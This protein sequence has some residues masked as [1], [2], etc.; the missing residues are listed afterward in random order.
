M[1]DQTLYHYRKERGICV[2]CGAP[3]VKGKTRCASCAKIDAVKS[4]YRYHKMSEEQLAIKR[5]RQNKWFADHHDRVAIYRQR[6][7]ERKNRESMDNCECCRNCVYYVHDFGEHWMCYNENSK[8]FADYMSFSQVCD[9]FRK[10][11][12]NYEHTADNEK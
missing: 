9:C 4:K 12:G 5:E 1:G 11:G 2:K 3:A 8:F 6:Q 7:A 10:R